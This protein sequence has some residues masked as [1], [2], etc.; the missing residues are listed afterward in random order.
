MKALSFQPIN[1][2]NWQATAGLSLL[3]EQKA[4]L[5]S[6]ASSLVEAIYETEAN[7]Q[8]Y[9]ICLEAKPI[10]LLVFGQDSEDSS[11]CFIYH[12]MIEGAEQGKGYGAAAIRWLIEKAKGH[13]QTII[14]SYEPENKAASAFYAKLGFVETGINA[15]WGEMNAIYRL[16][17]D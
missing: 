17:G 1:R 13:Y 8:A 7:M 9:A 14:L 4:F 5:W 3:P 11:S 15:E 6:N 2:E 16:E 10:G 12:L